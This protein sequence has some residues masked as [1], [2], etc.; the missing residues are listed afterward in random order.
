MKEK[1]NLRVAGQHSGFNS[2]E[3]W[4]VLP[5]QTGAGGSMAEKSGFSHEMKVRGCGQVI[6]I[7]MDK[8]KP[9]DL[10]KL[11]GGGD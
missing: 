3:Q 2:E 7:I 11:V 4:C 6:H 10:I 5:G 1:S 9:K 8:G